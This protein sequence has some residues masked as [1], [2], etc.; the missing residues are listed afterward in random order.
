MDIG[1][2][3]IVILKGIWQQTTTQLIKYQIL[4]SSV[5]FLIPKFLVG[6]V[7]TKQQT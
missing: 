6:N 1:R 2:W 5:G 4:T 7:Y 3:I